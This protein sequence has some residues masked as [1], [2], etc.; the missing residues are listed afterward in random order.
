MSLDRQSLQALAASLLEA[1][2]KV[3]SQEEILKLFCGELRGLGIPLDR[4]GVNLVTL[5]PQILAVGYLWTAEDDHV[6]VIENDHGVLERSD[7]LESPLRPVFFGQGIVKEDLREAD[8][9]LRYPLTRRLKAEGYTAYVAL[10]VPL[11]EGPR[12]VM[13]LATRAPD[14]L[15]AE[16][17][18][19]VEA[20]IPAFAAV[21]ETRLLAEVAQTLLTTY[22]GD[23]AG[24]KVWDGSIR[25]GEGE[26]LHALVYSCDLHGFTRL[27]AER[28]LID[29]TRLLNAFFDAMG[30]P[31]IAQG[32]EILKFI[33]DA[34]LAVFPCDETAR[35][36]CPQ[37]EAAILAAQQGLQTL[38]NL[39]R[40]ELGLEAPLSAGVALAAGEVLYGNIGVANRLDFT[41]VGPAV[42]M[43][44]RLQSLGSALNRSLLY[45][46]EVA[47]RLARQSQDLGAFDLKGVPGKAQVF[48]LAQA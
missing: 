40:E 5:H 27:A 38:A 25:R 15:Q 33:G 12:Q 11:A 8:S 35:G 28:S 17:I 48:T 18:A 20:C 10:P 19:A 2:T 16:Q 22:V 13:T 46:A 3:T 6:E 1:R 41:V 32:G 43:A 37:A 44:A 29:T 36:H 24:A 14:G 34:I 26:V 23:R 21:L 4:A 30:Q 31:L 7:F 39:D 47:Q 42:N 45:S 9:L